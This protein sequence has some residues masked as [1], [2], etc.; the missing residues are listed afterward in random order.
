MDV[1][2][3]CMCRII[4]RESWFNH[5]SKRKHIFYQTVE[6]NECIILLEAIIEE[7]CTQKSYHRF[8]MDQTVYKKRIDATP[9]YYFKII[10]YYLDC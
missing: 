8:R 10:R 4:M 7:S 5:F 3:H 6:D 1:Y 2:R 9:S